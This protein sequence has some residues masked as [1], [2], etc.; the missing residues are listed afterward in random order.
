MI[1]GEDDVI[2]QPEFFISKVLP[3]ICNKPVSPL[4]S[5]QTFSSVDAVMLLIIPKPQQSGK[6]H[7]TQTLPA[8][9]KIH[10]RQALPNVSHPFSQTDWEHL[11]IYLITD[12][13]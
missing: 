12:V 10:D 13:R 1:E 9:R 6:R 7:K 2:N 8:D 5:P 11:C 4:N 3:K